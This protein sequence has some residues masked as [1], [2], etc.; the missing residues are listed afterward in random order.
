MNRFFADA[1]ALTA[2]GEALGRMLAPGDAVAL[3]GPLGAGKTTLVHGIARGL[4]VAGETAS[5]TFALM[6]VYDGRV[7]VYHLDMYRLESPER[8]ALLGYEPEAAAE[9]VT[10]VEW[11]DKHRPFWTTDV[12]TLRLAYEGAG[13]RL[14]AT[15]AGPRSA[16]LASRWDGAL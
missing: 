2:A 5:P 7:P 1:A 15:G 14:T 9:G 4:G 10:L 6:H 3:E 13:R 8:L 16:A 12:L 11:A